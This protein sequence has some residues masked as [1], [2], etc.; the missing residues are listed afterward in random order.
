MEVLKKYIKFILKE[1]AISPDA[2]AQQGLA[3]LIVDGRRF[4]LYNPEILKK[5]AIKHKDDE[6]FNKFSV[7]NDDHPGLIVG[8]ISLSVPADGV[9]YN[10]KEVLG[11]A[12]EKG[13]GPLMYDIAMSYT[14]QMMSDRNSV[15][16]SA[17]GIW[18]HYKNKRSD[19][20]KLPFDDIDQPQTP[21]E[22]DDCKVFPGRDEL[23]YA[24]SS[25]SNVNISGLV[26]NHQDFMKEFSEQMDL[27]EHDLVRM[28]KISGEQFFDEKYADQK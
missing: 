14:D 5:I 16:Q 10:A 21:P 25:K 23:N 6:Y 4:F 26:K 7:L 19:V 8:F 27:D 24:Y 13:Y 15:S 20:K 22:E 17:S 1:A 12:A 9:C 3:L 2:A 11:S 28:I 18:K